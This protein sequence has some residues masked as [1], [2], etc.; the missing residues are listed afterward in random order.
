MAS[1]LTPEQ[2]LDKN[3]NLVTRHVLA[4]P[5]SASPAPVVPAPTISAV[6]RSEAPQN[7]DIALRLEAVVVR[8]YLSSI[9][10]NELTR[11]VSKLD[12]SD[13]QNLVGT[14]EKESVLRDSLVH[15]MSWRAKTLSA[16]HYS[17]W[18]RR[19]NDNHRRIY[20]D[21]C[22]EVKRVQREEY[23]QPDRDSGSLKS[24]SIVDG[25]EHYAALGLELNSEQE[26]NLMTLTSR[27]YFE[28]IFRSDLFSLLTF[29]DNA[30]GEDEL[31]IGSEE[32]ILHAIDSP[33]SFD[34]ILEHVRNREISRGV[35]LLHL[36]KSEASS[37]L[38]SG[39]L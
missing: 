10:Q 2:R 4:A 9:G 20:D 8:S 38:T 3:G 17:R 35:E 27:I 7:D 32:L 31:R 11:L 22:G 30:G 6:V 39:V 25:V 12:E 18:L 37:S 5:H 33:E 13:I 23:I 16:A 34:T 26:N 1:N 19:M 15:N 21:Y 29:K 14:L 28:S 24:L 36:L